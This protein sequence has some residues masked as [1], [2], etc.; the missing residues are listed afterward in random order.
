[1]RNPNIPLAFFLNNE[2]GKHLPLG[3]RTLQIC[4]GIHFEKWWRAL[5]RMH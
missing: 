1:M 4:F 5:K 2:I 3:L